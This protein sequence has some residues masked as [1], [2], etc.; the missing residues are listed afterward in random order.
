M[1][2]W[3]A[4][5]LVLA[6]V[7]VYLF[8]IEIFSVAFKL[9]GLV[10]SKIRLQVACLFTGT[11]YTTTESE[12]IAKDEKRRKIAIACMYTG[13]IFSVAFMGTIINVLISLTLL[14]SRVDVPLHF[15]EWYFIVLYI[16]SA[17]FL[18]VLF[19]KIPPVNR[20]FQRFLESIA[21]KTSSKNKKTN[22]ITVLDLQGKRA[23]VE[24]ILNIIPEYANEVSLSEMSLTRNYSINVLS[25][26]RDNRFIEV[27]KDTM[28]RKGDVLVIYGLINDIKE[29]FINSIT[30]DNK[31]SELDRT[32]EISLLNN[33]GPNAIVEVYVDETPKELENVEIED[34]KLKD[35]Y[36]ITVVMIKRKNEY[37]AVT[38]DTIVKDGDTV[39]LH[40]P[41]QN[42]KMLFK[43]DELVENSQE[44]P[45][46][47]K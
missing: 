6:V 38:K 19:I 27:T 39:T 44:K 36:G 42:I 25:I 33:Y 20:R 5:S 24:L 18:L 45:V 41:Y 37:V 26:K 2:I 15:T 3:L 47:L 10:T 30:K 14:K 22:I 28:F 32:N 7:T 17:L 29:A 12:L 13:H 4:I 31:K 8:V 35:R 34:A 23:I 1:N 11:G 46:K 43:N 40:G 21:L 16:T 9:T